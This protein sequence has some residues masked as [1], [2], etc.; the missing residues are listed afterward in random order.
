MDYNPWN[1]ESIWTEINK[2]KVWWEM[3]YLPSLKATPYEIFLNFKEEKSRFTVEKPGRQHLSQVIKV[4]VINN[5]TNRNQVSSVKRQWAGH[6]ITS[7]IFH[8]TWKPQSSSNLRCMTS[9]HDL[10]ERKH[11]TNLNR[12]TVSNVTALSE[13]FRS[14]ESKTTEYSRLKVTQETGQLHTTWDLELNLICYKGHY[15]DKW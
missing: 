9:M 15:L 14:W 1:Q 3:G 6:S 2:R 8:D 11:Q 4:N 7:V 13:V 5:G 12:G 10:I